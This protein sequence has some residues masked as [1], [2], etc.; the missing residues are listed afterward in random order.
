[1]I[2]P[3][4]VRTISIAFAALFLLSAWHKFTTPEQFCEN[5]KNYQLL[6]LFL[7]APVGMLLPVIELILGVGWLNPVAPVE[8]AYA[9]AALLALYAASMGINL[10]RGRIH[11]GCG[12]GMSTAAAEQPLSTGLLL[13]NTLFIAVALATTLP[14]VERTLGALDY[15][16]MVL[17]L[18][19]TVLLYI[20]ASQLLTNRAAM[21]SW[22]RSHD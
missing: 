15:L 6:P 4:I 3:L 1:M 7:V 21:A 19:A 14:V 12:C 16:T 5:I 13:R 18:L 11:I 20:A 9:S 17:A 10:A 8:T 2:D 22:S